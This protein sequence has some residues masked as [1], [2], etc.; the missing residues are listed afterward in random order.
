MPQTQALLG[1]GK[2]GYR[3]CIMTVIY[4]DFRLAEAKTASG[5]PG[6]RPCRRSLNCGSAQPIR[7]LRRQE[8]PFADQTNW[9]DMA[10]QDD[11]LDHLRATLGG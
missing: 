11:L 7:R 3:G 1:K 8:S 9:V 10:K 4:A 2:Q 5:R 6:R